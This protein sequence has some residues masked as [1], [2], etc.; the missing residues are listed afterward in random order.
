MGGTT[1]NQAPV[2]CCFDKLQRE[3]V[4]GVS[5]YDLCTQQLEVNH[6][7][8]NPV[9]FVESGNDEKRTDRSGAV[10]VPLRIK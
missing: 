2:G 9:C 10:C 5:H 3:G 1:G 8:L 7:H 4:T 6:V